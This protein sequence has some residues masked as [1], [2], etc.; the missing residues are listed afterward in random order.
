MKEKRKF[1]VDTEILGEYE[2]KVKRSEN[3]TTYKMYRSESQI[4]SES[5]RGEFLYNIIDHGN[6]ITLNNRE[7]DY[8][9]FYELFVILKAVM[10][11]DK[12]DVKP[13]IREVKKV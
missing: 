7:F 3:K 9:E 1:I 2:I 8:N 11:I 13:K 6:G 5:H 10:K 12:L 4:W